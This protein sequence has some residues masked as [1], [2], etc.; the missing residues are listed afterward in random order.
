[1]SSS[2][3]PPPGDSSVDPMVSDSTAGSRGSG[4]GSRG[5]SSGQ[6]RERRASE[7][8]VNGRYQIVANL[9]EG[10]MGTISLARDTELDRLVALKRLTTS[11][12]S[13]KKRGPLRG[14]GLGLGATPAPQR[15]QDSRADLVSAG[16]LPRHGIRRG[17]V[18]RRAPRGG[19]A[20]DRGDPSHRQEHGGGPG[21]RSRP[22]RD[23]P[24]PQARQRDARRRRARPPDRLWARQADRHLPGPDQDRAVH[25]HADLRPAR[26]DRR[27]QIR[28]PRG[29]TSTAWEPASTTCSVASR[30]SCARAWPS[31]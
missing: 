25:W 6:G 1:M 4:S 18:P 29:R 3:R 19:A 10:G 28:R 24:R 30:P 20:R 11:F 14:R 12:P 8:L 17:R 9:G 2:Q 27:G 16:P 7:A 31:S 13:Q 26:A 22:E 23:P 21:P 5:S 15:D